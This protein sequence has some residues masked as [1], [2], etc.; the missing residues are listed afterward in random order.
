MKK[1]LI[2]LA[3]GAVAL[4]TLGSVLFSAGVYVTVPPKPPVTLDTVPDRY[5]RLVLPGE[6]ADALSQPVVA[7]PREALDLVYPGRKARAEAAAPPPAATPAEVA[8]AEASS[9]KEEEA[10]REEILQQSTLLQVLIGTSGDAN[11]GDRVSDLFAE[12]AGG[13]SLERA[14]S[15]VSGA[16]VASASAVG[17]RAASGAVGAADIGDL[18][19][20][21]VSAV[22]LGAGPAVAVRGRVE[23]SA[24]ASV[25]AWSPAANSE[26]YTDYGI[27][28][29]TRVD[30]DRYSTFSI[31]VDT[32][33]YSIAR[34]KLQSGQLPPTASV[35]VE[36]FV[37]YFDYDYEP[38]AGDVQGDSAPFAVNMEG[39][40][41]P[42]QPSHHLLRFGVQGALP[43]QVDRTPVHLTFLVDTSGSMSSHDKLGLAQRSL[44]ELVENLSPTDTVAL[45]TYA[46]SVREVLAPTPISRNRDRIHDAIDALSAGGGTGMSSGVELAYQMASEAMVQGHENRVIVLSDGDANIG[47]T[48]HEEILRTIKR[49]AEEGITL[50]T[51]GFGMG[52]YKDT[53][54]EQLADQGDGNYAYIDSI[55]EA[56]RVFGEDLEATLR[57][58]AR[59]VK[60]QVEFNPEAVIAYRLIG[61]ENR[62]IADRD[63]RNDAVD[64]GEIGA[65][66]TVTA[67]YDVVLA[68]GYR[69]E[70]LGVPLPRPAGAPGVRRG[71][72]RLPAGGGRGLLRRAA[73]RQPLH[74]R[75]N[76]RQPAAPGT[77]GGPGGPRRRAGAGGADRAGLGPERRADR[78]RP[79]PAPGRLRAG[80]ADRPALQR[81]GQVLL[82]GAAEDGP[83][84]RGSG[85]RRVCGLGGAGDQ[86]Q[87]PGQHH[88]RRPAGQLH[89]PQGGALALP[90]RGRRRG[91]VPVCAGFG[92]GGQGA[93]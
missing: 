62:D 23:L 53:M 2:P 61:Y 39:A 66:H 25:S 3:A 65:G 83:R 64:A 63:F 1:N 90:R 79:R 48:S 54:M 6:Q 81:P 72:P 84:A 12:D 73:A 15:R 4:T 20:A 76:L 27:N 31:D 7:V 33:S 35:R 37:N 42:F 67:L 11:S 57:V 89:P 74:R 58:I 49:Y 22:T 93:R 71:Q 43:H 77:G 18:S 34:R 55:D 82:R 32:A 91:S 44:H 68:D 80:A 69:G 26:A 40:P 52:N 70:D 36:E 10:H 16:E 85:R 21:G 29:M 45:G 30:R 78:R 8:K 75:G 86:R 50:S 17:V 41:H 88:R 28:D 47:R 60:I 92:I 56:R 59:D 24:A 5:T 14:L 87:R 51:I 13:E 9:L 46:G 38:P 19:A